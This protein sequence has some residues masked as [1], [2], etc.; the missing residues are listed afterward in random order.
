[1]HSYILT[2]R[3]RG[4]RV[5]DLKVHNAL[6]QG[7]SLYMKALSS[8]LTVLEPG[9]ELLSIDDLPRIVN[10]L[11]SATMVCGE[12]RDTVINYELPVAEILCS[13]SLYSNNNTLVTGEAKTDDTIPPVT[14][15]NNELPVTVAKNELPV[16]VCSKQ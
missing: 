13:T 2:Q 1:M 6:V 8:G 15:A 14:V 11:C 7:D 12:M 4:C 16:M 10:V 3:R 5:V 9:V